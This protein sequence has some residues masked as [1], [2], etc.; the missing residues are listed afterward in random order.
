MRG[1]FLTVIL[2]CA[3]GTLLS[4][5]NVI[6]T[7]ALKKQLGAIYESDQ[8]PRITGDSIQF[9]SLIDSMNLIRVEA[10]VK[11]HGWPGKNLMGAEGNMTVFLVIQHANLMA[12]EKYFPLMKKSVEQNESR[13]CDLALLEDRILMGRGKKQLYGSQITINQATGAQE[14][15]PIE[16]EKNLN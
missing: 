13:A 4:A 7:A 9:V 8:R 3:I 6:D 1:F 15:W 16:D 2:L 10:I 11:K 12:Q 5:Q 14:I